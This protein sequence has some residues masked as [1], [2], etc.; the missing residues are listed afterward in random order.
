MK[1]IYVLFLFFSLILTTKAQ[2]YGNE[3]ID[4]SKTYYKFKILNKGIYRISQ[5]DLSNAGI[6]SNSLI[7]SYFKLFRNGQEVPLFVTTNGQFAMGDYIEFLGVG[8]DGQMDV[9]LYKNAVHQPHDRKNIIA[10]SFTYFLTIEPF[11]VNLRYTNQ[12]N[13]IPSTNTKEDFAYRTL[14]K[15]STGASGGVPAFPVA[16]QFNDIINSDFGDGEGFANGGLTGGYTQATVDLYSVD[17][18]LTANVTLHYF[19]NTYASHNS[20]IN[21]GTSY[22]QNEIFNGL[23]MRKI[24]ATVPISTL[25]NNSTAISI[26]ATLSAEG[27]YY[28]ILSE[29]EYPVVFNARNAS[30]YE[31]GMKK[32][33]DAYV[34]IPNF[35]TQ[36]TNPIVYDLT[37]LHRYVVNN[38]TTLKIQFVATS[39]NKDKIYVTAQNTASILQ[40]GSISTVNFTNYANTNNQGNYVIIA[41]Q[42]SINSTDGI[43]YVEQYRAYRNSIAGGNYKA[44]V[45]MKDQLDDQFAFGAKHHPLAIRNFINY[46]LD[47]FTTKPEQL[48]IIG[49]GLPYA[50]LRNNNA[51]YIQ[52]YGS[53]PSDNLLVARSAN[54]N[55][56]QIGVGR[57]DVTN[58][59]QIRNYLNKV[60]DYESSLYDTLPASQT[61]EN[62]LWRKNVLHLGGGY[63]DFEQQT[64]KN[65]LESYKYTIENPKFGA[66]VKSLYKN[67][68]HPIQI[69]ESVFIDSLVNKGTSLI[70]FFGH[71]A[72]STL[73][74]NLEPE[75]FTNKGRYHLL[76]TNGCFVG[77]LFSNTYGYSDRFVLTPDKAAI[78]FLGPITL[79]VAPILNNYSTNFYN[80]LS[81]D[82]Y[83]EPIGNVLKATATKVI[84]APNTPLDPS[85]GQ[86]MIFH[87]DPA[88]KLN[89]Y[90]KPDYYID[91]SSILFFPN[92]PSSSDDSFAVNIIIQNLGS[93][94][95]NCTYNVRIDRNL[96]NGTIESYTRTF[97]CA[98]LIDTVT[99]YV[100]N[101]RQT[102]AGINTFTIKV[103]ANDQ[104]AEYS[105]LNNTVTV[106]K[107][108]SADD[109]IPIFPYEFCIVNDPNFKM[110]FS[111]ADNFAPSRQYI[112]QIDTTAYFNSPLLVTEKVNAAGAVIEWDPN[113]TLLQDKVYY[114]RGTLDTIYNNPSNWRQSSFLYNTSLSTG[115]NQSHY[116]QYLRDKMNTLE[117]PEINRIF[118]YPNTL[119]NIKIKN[120]ASGSISDQAI[121][122]F[123]DGF[124]VGRNSCDRRSMIF[125]V[126][127]VNTG[128]NLQTYQIG[129]TGRGPYGDRVCVG[130]GYSVSVI[131]FP[132]NA[133]T[134]SAAF[135]YRQK[136]IEFLNDIPNNAFVM[137]YSFFNAGYS[138]WDNDLSNGGASLLDAFVNLGVSEIRN[139]QDGVPF[140]FFL[141]KGN[142]FF[143][144]V[145][146][147]RTAQQGII[148]TMFTFSGSWINGNMQSTIIGPAKSWT[149]LQYNWSALED[150]TFDESTVNVI[151]IDTSGNRTML[152]ADINNPVTSLASIDAK[153]Y[154]FLQL[155]WSTSDNGNATAPQLN[156]WRIAHAKAPEG[157]INPSI[158][159]TQS[160]D[161]VLSGE[162]VNA[163]VAFQ[164][165]T[166]MNMDSVLVKFTIV[167]ANNNSISFYKRFAA[168]PALQHIIITFEHNFEGSFFSGLN[169]VIIEANPDNDQLEQFH[170]NNY[171]EF[172]VYVNRDNINPILDV[173]FD[174]RHIT[175]G[176]YI[177]A[178]PEIL[179]KLKDENKNLALDDTSAFLIYIYYPNAPNTPVLVSNS[180]PD[181]IFIPADAN[182]LNKTNE[183]R[184]V[185]KPTLA[186]GTYEIRVQGIDR[187][188]NDAGKYDYRIKFKVDSKPSITNLLNYP[189]PFSTST[190]FIFTLTGNQVPDNF[191]IQIFSASGKVVKEI[192]QDELGS[193]HIGTNMTTY[194]WNG[195]D[196]YG[197]RLANGVYF[198]RVVVKDATG[199][200][201]DIKPSGAD[202]Y[203]K[204]GYGKMYIVR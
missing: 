2:P 203:F 51:D 174:G 199:K 136:C 96:P 94:F 154:P 171:A 27:T 12:N 196:N 195:T 181:V 115:W 112:F 103:D 15:F 83:N 73:D 5:T 153:Q 57:L 9:A 190:Q 105:E 90:S 66:T 69:A 92:N 164:N 118:K 106:T 162:T 53:P 85:I 32:N 100:K 152:F 148:D 89:T 19:T 41:N 169:K 59:N 172:F 111:T 67:S 7:G 39:L 18:N 52:T 88:I 3:W 182:N 166:P 158:N 192:T 135:T 132:T 122:S 177:S 30:V 127:D 14:T 31:F 71:S 179:F 60:I 173:T 167:N 68:S 126:F 186:D 140:V 35:N 54:Q 191:M 185:F 95:E 116:F 101:N 33:N 91:A 16:T 159:F 48:F 129:S 180:N 74:F 4:Y 138:Q 175:D 24:N 155:E 70:T 197:D 137:G 124:L 200:N 58:G 104:I 45:Y 160:I 119:R 49:R 139:Q 134:A 81:Y 47:N 13:V 29:I 150:P 77:N 156:Y 8:N 11:Q 168:L 183:A 121:E 79:A 80:Q 50:N 40:V 93:S 165:V 143:T 149:D 22:T 21:I 87:G 117:L 128:K 189:N 34:E 20:R 130:N 188:N 184:I 107:L 75:R 65:Y 23:G 56:P 131:E 187:S 176:E 151:G 120:G 72:T 102:S 108:I 141:Q 144:P 43:D 201:L 161:T 170:F 157:V 38:E 198:F 147:K 82:H 17:P 97:N 78:G 110:K 86:Q 26:T 6:P 63:S 123:F 204:N 84:G 114:W 64:F 202:K 142:P 98:T 133:S 193:L 46:A 61:P 62:K 1:K 10:D 109:I 125:F 146:I 163:T 113:V 37:N 76:L 42:R 145:Q 178:Q 25:S 28:P 44:I 55:T 99:M 194:K 36:S